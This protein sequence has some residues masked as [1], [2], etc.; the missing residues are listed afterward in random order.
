MKPK[1]PKPVLLDIPPYRIVKWDTMNIVIESQGAGGRWY[2][3]WP[4][5][6][7]YSSLQSALK[8][9]PGYL[10]VKADSL[11]EYQR[12]CRSVREAVEKLSL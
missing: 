8:A 9:M 11:E 6:G 2:H 12:L 4:Y 10:S 5:G 7:Y 3:E 1:K